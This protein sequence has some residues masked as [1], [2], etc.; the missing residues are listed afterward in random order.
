MVTA[1]VSVQFGQPGFSRSLV[2]EQPVAPRLCASRQ[3]DPLSI[4]ATNE[5]AVLQLAC[6]RDLV[7]CPAYTLG[8]LGHWISYRAVRLFRGCLAASRSSSAIDR[9]FSCKGNCSQKRPTGGVHFRISSC[10]R[11]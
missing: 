4:A 8:F 1:V 11:I 7:L 10:V 5:D 2:K 6:R 3:H 9:S